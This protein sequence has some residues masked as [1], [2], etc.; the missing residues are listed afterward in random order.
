LILS[1]SSLI[2]IIAD[3]YG[4][5]RYHKLH[6]E[7]SDV[8]I[9]KY[10]NLSKACKDRVVICFSVSIQN[11]SRIDPFLNSI[12]DQSVRVDEIM[13]I[14]AYS[15]ISKISEKYKKVC[16]VQGYNKNYDNN[17]GLICSVLTEPDAHT[18]IIIVSPETVYPPD[19]VQTLVAESE[20]HPDKIIYG[21][22]T[23]DVKYGVLVKPEFFDDQI[24]KY[25]CGSTSTCSEYLDKYSNT[26]STLAKCD[27]VY[28]TIK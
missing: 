17:A 4:Y 10:T 9:K 5:I 6:M 24:S 12:L 22:E 3:Y 14:T 20:K 26:Q 13:L 18:K 25:Q 19:F 15:D 8:Y 21:S 11:I 2:Y 28:Y 27:G 1:V 16:S 7:E 23:K